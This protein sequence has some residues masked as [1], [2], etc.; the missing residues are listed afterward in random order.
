MYKD[1]NHL[2]PQELVEFMEKYYT[3]SIPLKK[4]FQDYQ[5][6]PNLNNIYMSFP[7]IILEDMKC[8][9]CLKA[10][11]YKR[12]SKLYH[13]QGYRP[14]EAYCPKCNH[15]NR[16]YCQCDACNQIR[17][18][19]N[20]ERQKRIFDHYSSITQKSKPISIKDMT[21]EQRLHY[22]MIIKHFITEDFQKIEVTLPTLPA[23]IAKIIDEAIDEHI[24]L[25]DPNS[26]P[27]HF[28]E[29]LLHKKYDIWLIPNIIKNPEDSLQD[30]MTEMMSP[31]NLIEQKPN[32]ILQIWQNF[33][34]QKSLEILTH[35]FK[36]HALS[37]SFGDK[38]LSI[39]EQIVQKIP[40]SKVG[41][42]FYIA[43]DKAVAFS[44]RNRL[45][46]KHTMNC[47]INLCEKFAIRSIQ[48]NWIIHDRSVSLTLLEDFF[49]YNILGLGD[50]GTKTIPSLEALSYNQ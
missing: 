1:L 39:L 20:E 2:T 19:E 3:K 49:F 23:L 38:T 13:L 44:S 43:V 32:E 42:I 34:V 48:E 9:Y 5:I 22:G 30:I 37:F 29:N 12:K 47:A 15:Y 26:P 25:I 18:K 14:S 50:E 10:M 28:D 21:L 27:H 11:Q 46:K 4:L 24:F 40:L 17:I 33:C 36:M 41:Y 7:P 16:S 35:Y 6:S 45:S 8:P 31:K